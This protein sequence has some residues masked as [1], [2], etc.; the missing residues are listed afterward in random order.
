MDN[1]ITTF[2]EYNNQELKE[3]LDSLMNEDDD[4]WLNDCFGDI[5]QVNEEIQEDRDAKAME[6]ARYQKCGKCNGKGKIGHYHYVSGG[7][8]FSC[9]GRGKI[10]K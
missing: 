7:V 6:E 8:C 9:E 4:N 3:K 1:A 5:D 10:Y 2:K